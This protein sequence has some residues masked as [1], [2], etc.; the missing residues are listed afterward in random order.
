[1]ISSYLNKNEKSSSSARKRQ[2]IPVCC[3]HRGGA[4]LL[5]FHGGGIMENLKRSEVIFN[6]TQHIS[7]PE[8]KAQGVEEFEEEVRGRFIP[9]LNFEELPSRQAVQNRAVALVDVLTDKFEN[10]SAVHQI[11]VMVG[12]ASF[13]MEPL[14]QELRRYGFIPV[15]AFSKRRSVEEIQPDGSVKKTSVF[16]HAGFIEV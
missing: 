6:F 5:N 15:F 10:L 1:L 11:R 2:E 3:A 12:G 13:L 8:Q 14:C 9:L 7:T 16:V 4:N